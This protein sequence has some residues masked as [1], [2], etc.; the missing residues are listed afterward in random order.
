MYELHEPHEMLLPHPCAHPNCP[1]CRGHGK[2]YVPN[3]KP[4]TYVDRLCPV[5]VE[6]EAV[7]EGE[8]GV[9]G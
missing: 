8:L 9:A 2:L 4:Y 6:A 5:C 3:G 1:V 7:P